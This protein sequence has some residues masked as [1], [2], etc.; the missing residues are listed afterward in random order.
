MK[1]K[2]PLLF[3][4]V[5]T[6]VLLTLGVALFT[7]CG[8]E[9]SSAKV[10]KRTPKPAPTEQVTPLPEKTAAPEVTA[11]PEVTSAPEVTAE[12]TEA[13]GGWSVLGGMSLQLI[14]PDAVPTPV[15]YEIASTK[16]LGIDYVRPSTVYNN[17]V[18]PLQNL[19]EYYA[20][21][22][23]LVAVPPHYDAGLGD[24]NTFVPV[25]TPIKILDNCW[26]SGQ[27]ICGVHENDNGYIEEVAPSKEAFL[28]SIEDY[29]PYRISDIECKQYN[30]FEEAASVY[31]RRMLKDDELTFYYLG[32][33]HFGALWPEYAELEEGEVPK[34]HNGYMYRCGSET[35]SMYDMYW[36]CG[37]YTGLDLEVRVV[38]EISEE[39][40]FKLMDFAYDN[41]A[42]HNKY[43]EYTIVGANWAKAYSMYAS[44]LNESYDIKY[45]MIHT[46][47][48]MS[49]HAV[50]LEDG[51]LLTVN[52]IYEH[53]G[54]SEDYEW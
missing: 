43:P 22:G 54:L 34:W 25:H 6:V 3:V 18:E 4:K 5:C 9:E 24:A 38:C 14:T 8:K 39:D 44:P 30:L 51:T 33:G 15:P 27:F 26:V 48:D 32:K 10:T 16:Y 23:N 17:Y 28:A 1:V 41:F 36:H 12:L 45:F 42:R 46:Y 47:S 40:M 19:S 7:G 11:L 52:E 31:D 20:P 2:D 37:E 13:P 35:L 21:D 53:G 50:M 49:V 29:V